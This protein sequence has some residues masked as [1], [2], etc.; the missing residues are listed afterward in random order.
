MEWNYLEYMKIRKII[1]TLIL[2][3]VLWFVLYFI[4]YYS[5]TFLSWINN[6]KIEATMKIDNERYEVLVYQNKS[7]FHTA[8]S[9]TRIS[10]ID[11]NDPEPISLRYR[12]YHLFDDCNSIERSLLVA[13]NKKFTKAYFVDSSNIVIILNDDFITGIKLIQPDRV[14]ID[15][16]ENDNVVKYDTLTIDLSKYEKVKFY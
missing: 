7:E 8:Y 9:S 1:I 13:F 15:L 10:F 6:P 11:R 4:G 5:I 3:P 12:L 16:S 14:F 2:A